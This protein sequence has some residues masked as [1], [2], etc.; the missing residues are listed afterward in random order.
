MERAL[1]F[2]VQL[3]RQ[4]A[5]ALDKDSVFNTTAARETYLGNARRYAGQL[6]VDAQQGALY[7]VNSARNAYIPVMVSHG[8]LVVATYADMK[9]VA[10]GAH[11]RQILVRED[12]SRLKQNTVYTYWPLPAGGG[13]ITLTSDVTDSVVQ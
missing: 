7:I 8:W 6:V 1:E 9:A 3:Q 13:V 5:G 12:E 2:P 10:V 4:F 11:Q